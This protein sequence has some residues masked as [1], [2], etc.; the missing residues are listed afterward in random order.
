[1]KVGSVDLCVLCVAVVNPLTRR[2]NREVSPAVPDLP[3]FA[4][5]PVPGTPGTLPDGRPTRLTAAR[6]SGASLPGDELSVLGLQAAAERAG[7]SLRLVRGRSLED[8]AA[9]LE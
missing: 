9:P 2:R 5:A 4:P 7:V 3:E 1:R 6:G 8:A